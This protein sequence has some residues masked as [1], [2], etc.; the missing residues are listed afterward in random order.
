M[1]R[2]DDQLKSCG[3][4][5]GSAIQIMSSMRGRGRHKDKRS[6]A[7]KKRAT[8]PER[9]EQK[10]DEG[11]ATMDKDE[12]LKRLEENEEYQKI[13]DC[14]S[15]RSEGEVEQNVQSYL[16]E[17]P[18]VVDEQGTV[19]RTWKVESSGKKWKGRRATAAGR[20]RAT[21]AGRRRR[22][23]GGDASGEHRRAGSDG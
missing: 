3:V 17:D 4:P 2:K 11:P 5:D 20:A 16:G 13:I 23:I 7:E 8:N 10:S 18:V 12:V 21:T 15:E 9:P 6:N 14:M 22:T 1:L 19:G